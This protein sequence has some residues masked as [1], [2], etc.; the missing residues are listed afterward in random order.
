MEEL[1]EKGPFQSRGKGTLS[2]IAQKNSD[3]KEVTETTTLSSKSEDVKPNVRLS[4]DLSSKS[5]G[6]SETTMIGLTSNPSERD[7][8]SLAHLSKSGLRHLAVSC[9]ASVNGSER[10]TS[11]DV[12]TTNS[13]LSGQVP[14]HMASGNHCAPIPSSAVRG[15]ASEMQNVPAAVPTLLTRHCSTTA[16]F[17]HQYLG[18]LPT[19]GSV[20]LPR[21]YAGSTTL[22]GFSES[23]P[24]PALA[25]EHVQNSVALDICLGQNISSGLMGT[26]SLCNPYSNALHQNLLTT[27]KPFPV[28]TIGANYGLEPW[29]SGT[30]VGF[31]KILFLC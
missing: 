18:T 15:C 11:E 1:R 24:C 30:M 2:Y 7:Q 10:V 8:I 9:Q 27:T 6:V 5:G 17:A 13:A 16:P 14:S 31:G 19:A 23:C 3:A 26:S 4:N 28:Q 12:S 22:C 25:G 21:C 20:A 29:D